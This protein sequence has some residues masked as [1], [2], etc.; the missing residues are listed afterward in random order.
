MPRSPAPQ[1]RQRKEP[2]LDDYARASISLAN[3]KHDEDGHFATLQY[4][5]C[6][7][8]EHAKEIAQALRRTKK[9]TG[10]TVVPRIKPADDGTFIVEFFAVHPSYSQKY[11][12]EKYGPDRTKWPYSVFKGDPNYG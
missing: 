7:T 1:W 6:Q 3:G 8:R 4:R 10:Y 5:G 9:Y 2:I 11:I 12:V